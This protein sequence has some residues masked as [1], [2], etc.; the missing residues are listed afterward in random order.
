MSWILEECFFTIDAFASRLNRLIPRYYS[1]AFEVEPEG[2]FFFQQEW[3]W[4]EFL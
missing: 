4:D 1:K 2:Q 3:G